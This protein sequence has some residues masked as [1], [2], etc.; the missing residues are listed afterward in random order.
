M[1]GRER[2]ACV[3]DWSVLMSMVY[4][5]AVK[6]LL[7]VPTFFRV[8]FFPTLFKHGIPSVLFKRFLP[9]PSVQNVFKHVF[10]AR[11]CLVA[12]ML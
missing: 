10:C 5:R 6:R 3:A 2:A 9:A 8:F 11:F 4:S 1:L 7:G 12:V